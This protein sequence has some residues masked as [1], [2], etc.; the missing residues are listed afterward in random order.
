MY[1]TSLHQSLLDTIHEWMDHKNGT[2]ILVCPERGTSLQTFVELV[3]RR[4]DFWKLDLQ[5]LVKQDDPSHEKEIFMIKLQ[6][7]TV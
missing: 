1:E 5:T 7:L 4:D 2:C 3:R 6:I